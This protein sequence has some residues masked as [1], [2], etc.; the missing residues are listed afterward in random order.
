MITVRELIEVGGF[1][2]ESVLAGE[3]FLDK[4]LLGVTSFDSPDGHRWLRAGEFVLTTGFPFLIR[5]N[6]CEATLIQLIDEL[7]AIGTPG[8]AIKL[9]RYMASVPA[10]V[11]AHAAKRQMPI[12]SFPM[13]KAWS[14]V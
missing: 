6:T 9:G 10:A 2:E 3:D 11:L 7:A 14:D 4:E 1:T 5:Q 13:D 8:L 12:L